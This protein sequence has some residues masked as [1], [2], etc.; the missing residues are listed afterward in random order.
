MQFDV[1]FQHFYR[2]L[3]E[4]QTFKLK[5]AAFLKKEKI[6]KMANYRGCPQCKLHDRRLKHIN[7]FLSRFSLMFRGI[8][9]G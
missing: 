9:L 8:Y 5:V 7:L 2:M 1:Y 3:A 6:V 4:I